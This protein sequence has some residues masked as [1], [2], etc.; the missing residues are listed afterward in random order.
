MYLAPALTGLSGMSGMI[1]GAVVAPW[2]PLD[3]GSELLQ[4]A[5]DGGNAYES[6]TL[7]GLEVLRSLEPYGTYRQPRQGR[8]W[9]YDGSNDQSTISSVYGIG[10]GDAT[11]CCWIRMPA[12]NTQGCFIKIGNN[13]SGFGIGV[14]NTSFSDS[15]QRLLA[16]YEVRRW[17]PTVIIPS[18]WQHVALSINS[19]G[20]PTVFLNGVQVQ[21][22]T[23]IGPIAP[24][25]SSV[26]GG[27][28]NATARFFN[29]AMRD[30][31]VFNVAKTQTQI[32]SIMAGNDDTVGLLA[33]YP[34]NEESGTIGYDISGNGNHLTHNNITQSTFHATDIGVPAN[35]NNR[36]GY[37]TYS[38]SRINAQFTT[39][40]APMT[41]DILGS[42]WSQTVTGGVLRVTI[43]NGTSVVAGAAN[44]LL[45]SGPSGLD[46]SGTT[47]YNGVLR[48][49]RTS[50]T[51]G[52]FT[53]GYGNSTGGTWTPSPTNVTSSGVSDWADIV[54][55][56]AV[57]G[58]AFMDRF[59]LSAQSSFTATS[60]IVFEFDYYTLNESVASRF[61]PKR[62][63]DNLSADGNALTATGLSPYP[64]TVETPCITGN[65]TDVQVNLGS[66]LIPASANFD[67]SF[68]LFPTNTARTAISQQLVGNGGNA[69]V[70]YQNPASTLRL[71]VA[72][73]EI[74]LPCT[75]LAWQ[76][77]R[78]TRVGNLFTFFVGGSST[79]I[80]VA[81]SFSTTNTIFF[82]NSGGSFSDGRVCDFRITTGGVTTF[83]PLQE[84]PGTLNTNRNIHFVRSDGT[85]GVVTNAIVNG[86]VAN[87]WA[88]RC[89]GHARDWA[90][91]FGGRLATNGAF[92]PGHITGNLCADGNTKTLTPGKFGNPYS[93]INFNPFTAAELNPL[94][95]GTAFPE[96][97]CITGDGSAVRAGLGASLIPATDDL[98]L[99]IWYFQAN[100]DTT[101]RSI[102]EQRSPSNTGTFQL[103][104]NF[105]G[106]AAPNA[107][108]LW[109]DASTGVVSSTNM[110]ASAWNLIR[111]TRVG[112]LWTLFLNG[113]SV[114][115]VTRSFSVSQ[116][117]N[118]NLLAA[119][120]SGSFLQFNGG[121]VSDLRITTGGVTTHF[122]LTDG[123]GRDL[124]WYRTDN[125]RG[126]ASNAIVGGTLSSIW[127]NRVVNSSPFARRA[128]VP[129]DTKFRRTQADGDDR[130]FATR[131]ALTGPTLTNA[132]AYVQ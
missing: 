115:T 108:T 97:P 126:I 20:H 35:R 36:H 114:G 102:I 42:G 69:F 53:V 2:S 129:R 22:D 59:F 50:G 1:G 60:D 49:R 62:L 92:V 67:L 15:G 72:G 100:S 16:L 80:T 23:S 45:V 116:L 132:E 103:V 74:T 47:I 79:T 40:T 56:N 3:L 26:F 38:A 9:L 111:V 61:V 29:D 31:R 112:N 54:L 78:V 81:A 89:P 68:Q 118:T 98:D 7:S 30:I 34:C 125:T 113:S 58:L 124:A 119:Q 95:V 55:T 117:Q 57:P 52:A 76:Q 70:I 91:Q 13:S 131:T 77:V 71:F 28:T 83:F 85:G 105:T 104:A 82:Q 86:T 121:R 44:G 87:I 120:V 128:I 18:G 101:I 6:S 51:S 25:T 88:N 90:T 14:G 63:T 127:A 99:S 122:P 106:G 73:Q 32:Q 65:G 75:P 11:I 43:P 64:A 4:Y 84:G 21:T 24:S 130:F 93:R 110:T 41:V 33:Q 5:L 109:L 8:C 17:I 10:S 46:T 66:A 39:N 27:H 37:A 19:S 123:S 48:W 96:Q 12:A 107:L 94:A